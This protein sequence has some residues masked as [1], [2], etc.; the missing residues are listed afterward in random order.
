MQ[1]SKTTQFLFECI[2]PEYSGGEIERLSNAVD[3]E[4]LLGT[5]VLTRT[6]P[7]I[8]SRLKDSGLISMLPG[9]VR[10]N[11]QKYYY[12]N[13]Q[14]NTLI[15]SEFESICLQL[16]SV[17]ISPI[18]LKGIYLAQFIYENISLRQLSDIDVLLE[19]KNIE[20]AART[21]LSLGFHFRGIGKSDFISQCQDAKHIPMLCSKQGVSIE[22][23][24]RIF[25]DSSGYPIPR[26]C[27]FEDLQT[28][29]Y[30]D[31]HA[32]VFSPELFIISLCL[33]LDEHTQYG[34]IHFIAYVDI[35][36]FLHKKAASFNWGKLNSLCAKHSIG[37]YVYPHI[38]ISHT[39]L[40]APVPDDTVQIMNK[41]KN[42]YYESFFLHSVEPQKHFNISKKNLNIEGLKHTKG[43]KNK[44]K[45]LFHDFFP[46]K[47]FMVYRYK[48]KNKRFYFLYY[49]LRFGV[50]VRRLFSYLFT[51]AK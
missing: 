41:Y 37:E 51:K 44:L 32:S 8:Y 50:G 26:S 23:H 38:L 19:G 15:Y 48:I 4:K 30:N 5:S 34:K 21:I 36:W 25:R 42:N 20:A 6:T 2:S 31:V 11:L 39:Y 28:I 47:S 7:L 22:L 1:V 18:L 12:K 9:E 35:A 13:L 49:F 33:H 16:N 27:F 3:W 24:M 14:K 46:S 43:N 29:G 40:K 45:Y 10:E 17:S